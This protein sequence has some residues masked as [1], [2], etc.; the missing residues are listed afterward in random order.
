MLALAQGGERDQLADVGTAA[1]GLTDFCVEHVLE[2][3]WGDEEAHGVCVWFGCG[4][5]GSAPRQNHSSTERVIPTAQ[6]LPARTE[7]SSAP[8]GDRASQRVARFAA[9][10]EMVPEGSVCTALQAV[11]P[12]R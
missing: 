7:L 6:E 9:V 5:G 12:H 1:E 11:R 4:T 2:L 10:L 3:V 8:G